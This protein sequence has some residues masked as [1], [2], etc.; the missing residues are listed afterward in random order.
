MKRFYVAVYRPAYPERGIKYA[1]YSERQYSVDILP[2]AVTC[3]FVVGCCA[4]KEEAVAL[5]MESA[6]GARVDVR[7]VLGK[8]Q[9]Q[10]VM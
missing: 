4:S 5:V 9:L 10:G 6:A 3:V 8:R 2:P 1:V 7:C